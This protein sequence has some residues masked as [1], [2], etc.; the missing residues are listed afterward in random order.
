MASGASG[1]SQGRSAW[2]AQVASTSSKRKPWRSTTSS[3]PAMGVRFFAEHFPPCFTSLGDI[4]L[5][6]PPKAQ[7]S[8]K[9]SSAEPAFSSENPT[10]SSSQPTIN[11]CCCRHVPEVR[12]APLAACVACAP[13]GL[14]PGAPRRPPAAAGARA[15]PLLWWMTAGG[16]ASRGARVGLNPRAAVFVPCGTG[17][18]RDD[19]F[20][21]VRRQHGASTAMLA[22]GAQQGAE[23][24]LLADLPEE[25]RLR[26]GQL[27][28]R[29]HGSLMCTGSYNS[30]A[31]G[32]SG[33]PQCA[34][35][36][37]AAS[38][39]QCFESQRLRRA[40]AGR[41]GG[42]RE[43]PGGCGEQCTDV[44]AHARGRPPCAA[45]PA[46][47][48]AGCRRRRL[49]RAAARHRRQLQR[50]APAPGHCT[51]SCTTCTAA[52]LPLVLPQE[53]DPDVYA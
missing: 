37:T 4:H 33:V 29:S 18:G 2:A 48:A 46:P 21:S 45:A 34:A 35:R 26:C 3:C 15:R 12:A 49:A 6:V 8:S 25:V 14:R 50:W 30:P 10:P 41:C 52:R 20:G 13:R 39:V 1:G 40:G 11:A 47:A 31:T 5:H 42:V 27:S 23:Q 38:V 16:G 43:R 9:P 7:P 28:Q 24:L 17:S 51:G 19:S 22:S 32:C 44:P 53:P 36:G